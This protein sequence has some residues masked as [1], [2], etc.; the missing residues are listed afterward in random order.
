[1]TVP[2]FAP[3]L[4]AACALFASACS[5]DVS[6]DA[7]EGTDEVVGEKLRD[8]TVVR[9][10]VTLGERATVAYEPSS[11][12][13]AGAAAYGTLPYLAMEIVSAP[14]ARAAS[15]A[16]RTQNGPTLASST[17][18]TVKGAFPGAPRVLVVD[19]SFKVLAQTT[20]RTASGLDVATLT[21]PDTGK[22]RFVL[23]RDKLWVKPMTFD[24]ALSR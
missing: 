14:S 15:G 7:D 2:R 11:P 17:T 1:M 4:L 6:P 20:A 9:G 5:D 24:V 22:K 10:Q 23:V 12:A 18:V 16:L 13:Y 19:E 21:T 3:A 8:L